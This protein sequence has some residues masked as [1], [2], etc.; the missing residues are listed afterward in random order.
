MP[1]LPKHARRGSLLGKAVL[2][3]RRV[4]VLRA[5]FQVVQIVEHAA[6]AALRSLGVFRLAMTGVLMV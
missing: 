6:L 1:H 4:D 3:I 5:A 2:A